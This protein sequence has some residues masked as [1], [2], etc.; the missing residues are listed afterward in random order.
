MDWLDQNRLFSALIYAA[1]ALFLFGGV[2]GSAQRGRFRRLA[3]GAYA[4]AVA[5]VLAAIARWLI[6]G[7]T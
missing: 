2:V 6:G 7:P 5:V 1:T 3:I 4:V